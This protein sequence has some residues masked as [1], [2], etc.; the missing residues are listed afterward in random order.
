MEGSLGEVE[1]K[2]RTAGGGRGVVGEDEIARNV[3]VS[4]IL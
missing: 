1:G 4:D 3:A 2:L